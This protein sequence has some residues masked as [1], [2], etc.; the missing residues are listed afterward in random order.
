MCSVT[1][2]ENVTV[3]RCVFRDKDTLGVALNVTGANTKKVTIEYCLFENLAYND[4][5]GGEPLRLGNSPY[6]G[7]SFESTVRYCIFRNNAADPE[8]ISIKSCHNTVEDCYFINNESNVTVRHGGLATIRHNRFKGLGG[9]RLYGYG[10]KVYNNLFEDNPGREKFAP[11]I[12][13]NGN[14]KKDPNWTDVHMPSGKA[15]SDGHAI[16]A[17][18]VANEIY[19]NRFKNCKIT[20]YYRK[21]Q[22]LQPKDLKLKDN[23]KVDN[24]E[25]HA[26]G[27]PAEPT[28]PIP[29]ETG[30]I[31]EPEIP[32][33]P[34]TD[35]ITLHTGPEV[36]E[37]SLICQACGIEEAKNRVSLYVCAGDLDISMPILR[38]ALEDIRQKA[39]ESQKEI[40]DSEEEG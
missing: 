2:C 28:E 18:N 20:I 40:A 32:E 5:N 9:I 25:D 19:G 29:S 31:Q 39:G 24:F 36:E 3:R 37:F 27:S 34:G 33:Q 30:E 38:R 1:D 4:K 13:A 16:Y 6:S 8:T 11:I 7:C 23:L 35:P 26:T 17:Q 14:K 21:D 10:N 15:A 12:I 22:K